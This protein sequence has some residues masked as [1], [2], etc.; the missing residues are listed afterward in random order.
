MN[1]DKLLLRDPI[2]F[3]LI[4]YNQKKKYSILTSC[5]SVTSQERDPSA[6]KITDPTLTVLTSDL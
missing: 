2:Q 3:V 5:I 6:I 1:F 4:N